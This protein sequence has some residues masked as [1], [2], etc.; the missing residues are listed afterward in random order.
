MLPEWVALNPQTEQVLKPEFDWVAVLVLPEWVVP[1]PPTKLALKPE[2]HLV[3]GC[4]PAEMPEF[5]CLPPTPRGA[6]VTFG[7]VTPTLRPM[8]AVGVLPRNAMIVLMFAVAVAA[9][10]AMGVLLG[11]KRIT[12]AFA[13]T[14]VVAAVT[15][16]GGG[17]GVCD[18]V[19]LLGER[20]V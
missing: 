18:I 3:V 1:N 12:L 15:F 14:V 4:E 5:C 19:G 2:F 16:I 8:A 9:M 7:F 6:N 17:V 10:A 11:D 20:W 13:A